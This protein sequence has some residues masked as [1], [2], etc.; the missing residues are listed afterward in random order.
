MVDNQSTP[1]HRP[2]FCWDDFTDMQ[3]VS[4]KLHALLH[5]DKNVTK[6]QGC[7]RYNSFVSPNQIQIQICLYLWFF[8]IQ[9]YNSPKAN[10][11]ILYLRADKRYKMGWFFWFGPIHLA[12]HRNLASRQK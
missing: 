11:Q 2:A 1:A 8:Q 5:H 9:R 7:D 12:I 6:T 10:L 3:T 4:A